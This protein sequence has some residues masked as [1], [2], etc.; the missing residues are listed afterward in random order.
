MRDCGSLVV[1]RIRIAPP[2]TCSGLR[3]QNLVQLWWSTLGHAVGDVVLRRQI[4]L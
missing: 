1:T 3:F 4:L 2:G